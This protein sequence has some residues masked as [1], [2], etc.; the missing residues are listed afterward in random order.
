MATDAYSGGGFG[1][2]SVGHPSFPFGI[3]SRYISQVAI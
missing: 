1:D 3:Y 2:R